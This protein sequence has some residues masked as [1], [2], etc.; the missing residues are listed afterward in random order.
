[1]LTSPL[2]EHPAEGKTT[3][4]D[5][6]AIH[7]G[8]NSPE[9]VAYRL[10][11]TIASNES[12]TLESSTVSGRATADRKWLLDTYAECLIAVK[13]PTS[14]PLPQFVMDARDKAL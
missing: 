11:R 13:T 3:M 7:L 1:M 8:E 10:L 14:R 9:H 6:P 5:A 2:R 4:A 12:K